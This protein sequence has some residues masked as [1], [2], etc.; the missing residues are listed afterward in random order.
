MT[1][2]MSCTVR[3]ICAFPPAPCI[4][5]SCQVPVYEYTRSH[6]VTVLGEKTRTRQGNAYY[7][8]YAR[9]VESWD[10]HAALRCF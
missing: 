8:I 6:A 2:A 10:A 5:L 3:R 9:D 1:N 4:F 7:T